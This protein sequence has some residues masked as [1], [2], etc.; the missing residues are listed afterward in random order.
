MFGHLMSEDVPPSDLPDV[1][2]E[3]E[4]LHEEELWMNNI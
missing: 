2:A 4:S 1:E 3:E